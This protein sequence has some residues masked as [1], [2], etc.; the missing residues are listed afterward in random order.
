MTW[1]G[2]GSG[3]RLDPPYAT[4]AADFA[5]L[6][7]PYDGA[8]PTVR[9][10]ERLDSRLRGNDRGRAGMTGYEALSVKLNG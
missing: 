8:H 5:K 1:N 3:I 4:V 6:Y 7:P 9:I 2:G 10:R